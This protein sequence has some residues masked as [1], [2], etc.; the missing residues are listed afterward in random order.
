MDLHEFG[1]PSDLIAI[2][3][4]FIGQDRD[5]DFMTA[6]TTKD[7]LREDN[8]LQPRSFPRTIDTERLLLRFYASSDAVDLLNLVEQNRA[9]LT[10]EFAPLAA[11]RNIEE[12]TSFIA[13]K[14]NQWETGTTFCFG[15]WLK[16]PSELIG[17]LQVK[18]ISWRIPM[19]ELGCFITAPLQR[20]GY[21]TE[22]LQ[23]AL[24]L[25]F[26]DLR[27]EKIFVRILPTNDASL[28][29]SHKIG[30]RDE[31]LQRK[32]YRCGF[33]EL[34]DVRYLGLTSDDYAVLCQMRAST[35]HG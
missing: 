8:N 15:I 19:A 33:G 16:N 26:Q 34:H 17:Q 2:L 14:Q 29:M 7:A 35:H 10:R 12:T 6:F 4:R 20:Q 9:Q 31:G 18:N 32:A 21:G 28:K 30:F 22:S 5:H 23:A 3:A 13:D 11:L 27:F 24:K 1:T 25:S